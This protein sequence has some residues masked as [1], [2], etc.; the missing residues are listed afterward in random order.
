MGKVELILKAIE[1]A[2]VTLEAAQRKAVADELKDTPLVESA[3]ALKEGQVAVEEGF[4]N[5]QREDLKKWKTEARKL[6]AELDE[7][8]EATSSGE[9]IHKKRYE[10]AKQRIDE[11]EPRYANLMKTQR[12]RWEREAKNI[13]E[14]L[15]GKFK[16]ADPKAKNGEGDLSDDDILANLS[17]AG[18]YAELGVM[19]EPPKESPNVTTGKTGGGTQQAGKEDWTKLSPKDRI[20]MGYKTAE[21]DKK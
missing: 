6:K 17:R 12:E 10:Q 1:D 15:K 3:S 21:A 20:A 8:K 9:S 5:S 18:E 14:K 4:Y 2:G 13:P 11:L 7:T 19:G 16:F